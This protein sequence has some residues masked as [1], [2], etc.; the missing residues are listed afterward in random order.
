MEDEGKLKSGLEKIFITELGYKNITIDNSFS[1]SNNSYMAYSNNRF[2]FD[3]LKR[4]YNQAKR[5]KIVIL[6][7]KRAKEK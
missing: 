3:A 2:G 1:T 7:F 4:D 6:F 5:K